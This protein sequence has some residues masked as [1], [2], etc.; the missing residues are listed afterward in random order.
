MDAACAA[1]MGPSTV[2]N[3]RGSGE[4]KT[5]LQ[6]A[7]VDPGDAGGTERE[8]SAAQSDACVD[9]AGTDC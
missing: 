6:P 3:Q 4:Q 9:G 2:D 7:S 5:A 8:D 1:S